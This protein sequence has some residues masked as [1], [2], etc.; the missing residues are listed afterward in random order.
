MPETAGSHHIDYRI[1]MYQP[2]AYVETH[3]HKVQEQV[4]H[5]IEGEGL[6]EIDGED[7]VVRRH[8]FIFLPPGVAH[9]IYN[10]GARRSGFSGGDLA[11]DRR[12]QTYLRLGKMRS[13]ERKPNAETDARSA[14]GGFAR[15]ASVEPD[16][17]SARRRAV[18]RP[19][20]FASWKRSHATAT[21]SASP[22]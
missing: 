7:H 4:Y 12:R 2:K 11:G 1:S 19:G 8:D 13:V 3:S 22:N 16:C 9:A 14:R 6:M 17:A 20:V 15:A 21:A 5:V 18:D 10:T